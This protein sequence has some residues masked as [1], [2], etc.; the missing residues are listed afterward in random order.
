M[1]FIKLNFNDS[2]ALHETVWL[3]FA[4]GYQFDF[5]FNL[6]PMNMLSS[7]DYFD[8]ISTCY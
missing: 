6:L 8:N 2:L 5:P 7:F 3:I 4:R 1:E